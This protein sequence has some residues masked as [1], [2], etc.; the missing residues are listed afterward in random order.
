MTDS[1]GPERRIAESLDTITEETRELVRREVRALRDETIAGL[2][3]ALPALAGFAGAA[4][5]AT[6]SLAGGYRLTV[7]AFERFFG[8]AGG[9]FVGVLAFLA[10]GFLLARSGWRRRADFAGVLPS[11]TA[12]ASVEGVGEGLRSD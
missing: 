6:W 12:R 11:G 8:P 1:A 9:T 10:G 2:R 3:G 7:R 4:V 5:L